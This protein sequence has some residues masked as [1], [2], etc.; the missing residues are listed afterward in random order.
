LNLV[1]DGD[2]RFQGFCGEF[3]KRNGEFGGKWKVLEQ[4]V[5]FMLLQ[6]V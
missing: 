2:L 5:K 3:R 1:F 6:Q 4:V